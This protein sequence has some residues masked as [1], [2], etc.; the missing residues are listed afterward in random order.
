MGGVDVRSNRLITSQY[1]TL[2]VA[3][4]ESFQGQTPHL[5]RVNDFSDL[6]SPINGMAY[7]TGAPLAQ[8]AV[9]LLGLAIICGGRGRELRP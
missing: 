2:N 5:A 1:P 7:M 4:L 6:I 9:I 3:K 8:M